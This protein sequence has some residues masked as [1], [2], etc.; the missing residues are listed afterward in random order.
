MPYEFAVFEVALKKR[1]RSWK[2]H[3]CTPEGTVVMRGSERDRRAAKY[4]ADRAFF[5]LLMSAP[6][7]SIRSNPERVSDSRSSQ[8][9]SR[10]LLTYPYDS[11]RKQAG[12]A[13]SA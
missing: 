7:R 2:W 4:Q 12:P 11:V 10:A 13:K 8:S 9:Y 1:G 5:I 6:Y 3:V